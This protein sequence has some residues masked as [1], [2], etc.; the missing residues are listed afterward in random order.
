MTKTGKKLN[1][2]EISRERSMKRLTQAA[3]EL[4]VIRGYHATSLETISS[5]AGLTKGSVYFYF[6]SKEKLV[7][8]MFDVLREDLVDG[9]VATLRNPVGN[10]VDRIIRYIH[11]GADFGAERP[12]ELLFMIQMAIEFARQDNDIAK[13]IRELYGDVHKAVEEV[14]QEAQAVGA[15]SS[16][17]D[18]RS[19]ASMI[20]AVHDGMMLEW[21]LRGA[22]IS[23]P[24]L[25]K[26]VRH[27]LLHG[28]G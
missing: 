19:F 8:Q 16:D 27:M 12:N 24:D 4:F 6:G 5:K 26:N 23:G 2:N 15:M 21:H 22:E 10:H 17:I 7:L 1:K 28:I 3:F 11:E 14:V 9:L 13:A 25:V 18:A 20:V